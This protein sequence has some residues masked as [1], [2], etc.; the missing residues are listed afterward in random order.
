MSEE[1]EVHRIA[2]IVCTHT[3]R[4]VCKKDDNTD[5]IGNAV[6][7]I[8]ERLNGDTLRD[9]IEFGFEDRKFAVFFNG[10]PQVSVSNIVNPPDPIRLRLEINFEVEPGPIMDPNSESDLKVINSYLESTINDVVSGLKT[11]GYEDRGKP[12]VIGRIRNAE[13]GRVFNANP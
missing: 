2:T 6:E 7:V 11:I 3:I 9:S 10:E 4:V 13:V 12:I 1:N 5:Y 8:K